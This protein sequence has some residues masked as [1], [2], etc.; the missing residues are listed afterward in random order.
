LTYKVVFFTRTGTCQRVAEKISDKLFC[1]AVQ[2]SDNKNWKG[3]LGF[4]KAGFYSSTNRNVKIDIPG[5]LLDAV[6]DYIVVA[7]LWAGGLAPAIMALF[8]AIPIEKVHLVVTS[9][10]SYLKNRL[11][12]KS[13]YDIAKNSNDEDLV[14]NGLVKN[15]QDAPS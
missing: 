11:G 2:I 15:L 14:I 5:N 4:I 8:R 13:I 10:G 9:D 3:F 1:E 12:Y 6:D 7:P